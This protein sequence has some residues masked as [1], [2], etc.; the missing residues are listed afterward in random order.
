MHDIQ[1]ESEKPTFTTSLSDVFRGVYNK[2]MKVAVKVLRIYTPEDSSDAVQK[3][4]SSDNGVSRGCLCDSQSFHN[5]VVTWRHL[6]HPNIVPF[7]G[8]CDK[9]TLSL[10]SQWMEEG[11]LLDFFRHHPSEQRTSYVSVKRMTWVS[12]RI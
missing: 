12:A 5:E 2:E 4:Y 1:L 7:L 11:T 9:S 8:V 10:V 6:Q 3:V